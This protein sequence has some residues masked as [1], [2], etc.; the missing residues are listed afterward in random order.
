MGALLQDV[1]YGVRMLR[2]NP[3]FTVIAAVTLILGIGAN[4]AVFSVVDPI[5]ALRFE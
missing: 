4:T 5:V 2:K 1:R 3:V